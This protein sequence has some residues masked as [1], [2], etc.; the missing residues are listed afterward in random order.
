MKI[1]I[2]FIVIVGLAIGV[3]MYFYNP[4]ESGVVT[5]TSADST[6]VDSVKVDTL[7]VI[8]ETSLLDTAK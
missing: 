3:I 8:N 2:R 1:L 6:Q 7:K 5:S 4:S